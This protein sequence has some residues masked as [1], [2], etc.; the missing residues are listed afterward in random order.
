VSRSAYT[1][2]SHQLSVKLQGLEADEEQRRRNRCIDMLTVYHADREGLRL[3]VEESLQ[4]VYKEAS[5]DRLPWIPIN[6]CAKIIDTLGMI[7][8]DQPIRKVGP[9]GSREQ[10]IYSQLMRES[11]IGSAQK[12]WNRY[13]T[14]FNTI[15][16]RPVWRPDKTSTLGGR[17]QL[18]PYTPDYVD[19]REKA[20]DY[21]TPEAVWYYLNE[22]SA[23]DQPVMPVA[24]YWDAEQHYKITSTIGAGKVPVDG[25]DDMVNPYGEL[26]FAVLRHRDEGVFWG[27]GA[28][29]IVDF[30]IELIGQ[31]ALMLENSIFQG[32]SYVLFKNLK[33]TKKRYEVDSSGATASQTTIGVRNPFHADQEHRDD[34]EPKIEFVSPDP[35]FDK[36]SKLLDWMLRVLTWRYGLHG[37]RVSG[38]LAGVSAVQSGVSKEYDDADLEE[39]RESLLGTYTEFETS[40][41]RKVKLVVEA[42]SN[43][44]LPSPDSFQIEWGDQKIKESAADKRAR[45]REEVAMGVTSVPRIMV[46]EGIS[47][48][49][50]SATE[51]WRENMELNAEATLGVRLPEAL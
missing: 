48:D 36:T 21:L 51:E 8:K 10:E 22:R 13:A 16:V 32:F 27:S 1:S 5:M 33:L 19:I 23:P 50:E 42:E 49:I 11:N 37:S 15:M 12:D 9:D 25:N 43:L 18:I 17:I 4:K 7:Y 41:Y 35:L 6:I 47:K 44:V 2:I 26:P 24:Y 30:S 29:D 34:P 38:I 28:D 20:G 46:D 14:L 3:L 45:Q 31:L 40:L 39:I